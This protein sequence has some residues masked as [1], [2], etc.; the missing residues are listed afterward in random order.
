V[1]ALRVHRVASRTVVTL[2][3]GQEVCG[4][5]GQLGHHGRF[6]VADRE[7]HQRA[8]GKGEQRLGG[9]TFGTGQAVEAVLV[10]GVVHAL[11]EIGLQLDGG[12]GN[13]VEEQHQIDA[14][15]IVQGV[16]HLPGHAQ[17]VGGV[18]G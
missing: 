8:A 15:L 2:V 14:V 10:D 9:V 7:V 12:D 6:A 3:E 4:R 13:A 11:G 5:A 1:A 18:A 17:P 16:L